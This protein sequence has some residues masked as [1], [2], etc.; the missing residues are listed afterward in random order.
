MIINNNVCIIAEAGINHNGDV[1]LAKRLIDEAKM[2]GADIVK[3][4]TFDPV[5]IASKNAA[6]A[7]YQKENTGTDEN[8]ISM[9]SRVCL[10]KYEFIELADYCKT[11]GIVF[12]STPFD[13][14]SIHF[15]NNLQEIWKIPSGAIT[16]YPFLVEAAK[17][18]KDIILSTGMCT[19]DEIDNALTVLRDNGAGS[20]I[21]LHCTTQYP[22]PVSEVNL[23]AMISIREHC[24]CEVGY[25]DHTEGIEIPIAAVALGA[26]VIEKHFTLDRTMD[27]PDHK[28]SL[29]P[30]ELKDMINSIRNIELA[31]GTGEKVP[32]Q[33]ELMNI[34]VVRKSIIASKDIQKGEVFTEDNLTTKRPGTGISPMRWKE[35]IGLRANRKYRQDD[36]IE[37]FTD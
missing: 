7:N 12:L 23:R 10:D 20:I 13:V 6:M 32:S 25:S 16:D 14:D 33:S 37:W 8:Q 1:K 2:A 24:G 36:M 30:H 29:E 18:G 3:F 17:T 19:M 35:I 21:I 22:T 27:G 4:Q 5:K 28:A 9:L 26:R 15:L 31:M 34:D 11:V